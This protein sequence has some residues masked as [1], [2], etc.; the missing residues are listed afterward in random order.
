M[1][2]NIGFYISKV[3]NDPYNVE[4]FKS[5]N[6][7]VE[8]NEV[9]DASVF[10]NDVDY[11]PIIPKFGMFNAAEVWGFTGILFSTSLQNSLMAKGVINKFR[12]IHVYSKSED[13]DLMNLIAISNDTDVVTRSDEETKEYYRLTGKRPV[14]QFK[15]LSIKHIMESLQ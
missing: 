11:N 13:K 8:K 9:R 15:N 14:A 1:N 5:L 7:A 4:I 10:F 3:N 6:E 2:K 12:L